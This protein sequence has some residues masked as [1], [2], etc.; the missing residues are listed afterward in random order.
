MTRLGVPEIEADWALFLDL[1][2]TLLDI[3]P[4]PDAVRVPDRLPGDLAGLSQCL[5][6]ALA[7]VSGRDCST[8][9]HLLAPFA[10]PGGFGHG[11]ELRSADG[12]LLPDSMPVPPAAWAESLAALVASRPGLLLERKPHGLAVH[13]RAVPD[14]GTRV[15]ESMQRL[16]ATRPADF[17]VLPAHMAFEIRPR[18]ATK[19]RAV[20]TLMA[21]P[22]FT[23]R[24]PVFVGDDVTDEDGMEAARRFGG[25][26]L[27]VGRD[28]TGGPAQVRNWIARA[29]A[30]LS[31]DIAHAQS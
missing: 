14:E 6:G 19:A 16:A 1:D 26:G 20:E 23:G 27:H 4:R 17:A 22:P 30:H 21:A 13:F 15:H 7:V 12:I 25:L 5:G 10:P 9:D 11:A 8:I 31:P 29:V 18:A 2:G 24:R 28:F 3:A